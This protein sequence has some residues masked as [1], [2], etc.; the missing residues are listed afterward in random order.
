MVQSNRALLWEIHRMLVGKKYRGKKSRASEGV[1][2]LAG[3][4]DDLN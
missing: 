4:T 3:K 1:K 2:A